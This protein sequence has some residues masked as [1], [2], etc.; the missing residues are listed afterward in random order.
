MDMDLQALASRMGCWY[1][2]Y[3]DDMTISTDRPTF[4]RAL[5]TTTATGDVAAGE[6]LSALIERHGFGINQKKT[7]L[8]GRGRRQV[9]TGLSVAQHLNV[10]TRFRREIRGMLHAWNNY[11]LEQVQ[12][13]SNAKRFGRTGPKSYEHIVKGKIGFLAQ[14]LGN[15]DVAVRRFRNQLDN[16][17]EG[18]VINLGVEQIVASPTVRVLHLSDFHFATHT[19][20]D[21]KPLL[22]RMISHLRGA[23]RPDLVL[24][25]G[26]IAQSGVAGDYALAKE[27]FLSL[28]R[29]LELDATRLLLVPG[30]HD[31]DRSRVG[32]G[33]EST[34]N[35]VLRSS[36]SQSEF[37]NVLTDDEEFVLLTRRGASHRS[38]EQDLLGG[39]SQT[40]LV[41]RIRIINGVRVA[42]AGFNSALFSSSDNDKGSLFVGLAQCNDVLVGEADLQIA[43]V[44]HPLDYL[45]D[46]D[47]ASEYEIAKWADLVLRGH[48]HNEGW[49]TTTNEAGSVGFVAAG[50]SY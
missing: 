25:S 26:D 27:L 10:Q 50:A 2:R 6:S 14:V 9:V 20:R 49:M 35:R 43:L 1:T 32:R 12:Q 37:E 42:V 7:R 11:S 48:L 22:D 18:K 17:T 39:R 21:S 3:A 16:L 5:A 36:S 34:Q 28:L 23:T 46:S 4:P 13:R 38:F 40:A 33:A 19:A 45:A 44:H 8:Q 24:V 30:N 41:E 15:D 29:A 47:R 31:V